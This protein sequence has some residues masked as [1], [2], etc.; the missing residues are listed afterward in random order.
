MLLNMAFTLEQQGKPEQALATL[1]EAEARIDGAR[2]SR[3]L[4]VLEFN[5]IV[6]LGH[7][8]RFD[9]AAERLPQVQAMAKSGGRPLDSVRVMWLQSKIA[10][11]FGRRAEAEELLDRVRRELLSRGIAFDTAVATL[12]LAV[13]YLEDGRSAEVRAIADELAKIFAAQR[14]AKETLASAKL[15]CE[16]VKQ[17]TVTAELARGWLQELRRVG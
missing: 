13:F 16:A 4:C 1:Q 12:E 6:N 7:L 2:E 15:F 3:L 10:A 8:G 11:G 17:E 5:R 9:E 14:V